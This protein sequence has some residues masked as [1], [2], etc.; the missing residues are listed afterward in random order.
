MSKT[1]IK[2]S[3]Q[4][5]NFLLE[6]DMTDDADIAE[7]SVDN[8]IDKTSEKFIVYSKTKIADV[9]LSLSALRRLF[10]IAQDEEFDSVRIADIISNVLYLADNFST[11][12]KTNVDEMFAD[13][14]Y[15]NNV[16]DID[17]IN[18]DDFSFEDEASTE[19][20][21]ESI[22]EATEVTPGRPA[23]PGT[24]TDN[25]IEDDRQAQPGDKPDDDEA[26]KP[27]TNGASVVDNAPAEGDAGA[28]NEEYSFELDECDNGCFNL[29]VNKNG[30]SIYHGMHSGSYDPAYNAHRINQSLLRKQVLMNPEL[31]QELYQKLKSRNCQDTPSTAP[32]SESVRKKIIADDILFG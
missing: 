32:V 8:D 10:E 12:K 9:Q 1:K 14:D 7:P 31:L 16:D 25:P 23:T 27:A 22:T 3:T 21:D 15:V 20:E 29:R 4:F 11:I 13:I 30:Q 5:I 26:P 18:T 2:K 6:A 24:A 19:Q 17:N 28:V